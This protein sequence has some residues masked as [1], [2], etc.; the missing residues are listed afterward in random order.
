MGLIQSIVRDRFEDVMVLLLPVSPA[1]R[2]VYGENGKGPP[3]VKCCNWTPRVT[4]RVV[5]FPYFRYLQFPWHRRDLDPEFGPQKEKKR[6][7]T[8]EHG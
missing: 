1:I 6:L 3:C 2:E 4:K 7:K 5:F 8:V